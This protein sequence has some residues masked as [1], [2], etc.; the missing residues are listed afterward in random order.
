MISALLGNGTRCSLASSITWLSKYNRC[1]D[2]SVN[3]SADFI[4]SVC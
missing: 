4:R 3:R 2:G 1:A